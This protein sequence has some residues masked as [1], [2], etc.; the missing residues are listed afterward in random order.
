[1]GVG[2]VVVN[3]TEVVGVI[4]IHTEQVRYEYE[5]LFGLRKVEIQDNRREVK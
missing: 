2:L 5:L 3:G 4:L 1:M